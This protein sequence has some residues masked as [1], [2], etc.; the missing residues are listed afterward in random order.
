MWRTVFCK[1]LKHVRRSGFH[2][3]WTASGPADAKRSSILF[4]GF[5]CSCVPQAAI[6]SNFRARCASAH[7]PAGYLSQVAKLDTKSCIRLCKT[8]INVFLCFWR[9][10]YLL[11]W[12]CL[13][14][15]GFLITGS[16]LR[17][18]RNN[19]NWFGCFAILVLWLQ[20]YGHSAQSW[21]P[22]GF[23]ISA[24]DHL[25]SSNAELQHC[26]DLREGCADRVGQNVKNIM[27][28]VFLLAM[29]V[30]A[31]KTTSWCCPHPKIAGRSLSYFAC[32]TW[33]HIADSRKC[34]TLSRPLSVL[35][36]LLVLFPSRVEAGSDILSAGAPCFVPGAYHWA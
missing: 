7:Y 14:V 5:N 19:D 24:D 35:C 30:G 20:L 22:L 27:L 29:L 9:I 2:S 13:S 26:A 25:T 18:H 3:K 31:R 32:T 17:V 21:L 36:L 34:F 16:S 12:T 10:W 23:I 11:L 8:P 6:Y 1:G 33:Y 4:N 15:A 28:L